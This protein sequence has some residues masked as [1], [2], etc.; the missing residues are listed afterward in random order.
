MIVGSVWWW[1]TAQQAGLSG[2]LAYSLDSVRKGFDDALELARVTRLEAGRYEQLHSVLHNLQEAVVAVDQHE[3]IITANPAMQQ[4]LAGPGIRLDGQTLSDIAPE[5]SLHA[6]LETGQ[7]ERAVAL[8]FAQRDWVSHR[9][10]IREHG[11]SWERPS[12]CMT[13]EAF[14]PPA[15]QPAHHAA[16]TAARST[17]HVQSLIGES[18]YSFSPN[19]AH[20]VLPPLT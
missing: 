5:L 2:L 3:H 12:R 15:Y 1:I 13:R 19:R 6:T 14:T 11:A 7:Q 18:R 17:P 4:V 20:C 8:R 16:Q 10:P 9:T